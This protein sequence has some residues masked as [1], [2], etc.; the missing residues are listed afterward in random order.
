M[1]TYTASWERTFKPPS[2]ESLQFSAK[3]L[4]KI[5]AKNEVQF[6]IEFKASRRGKFR[7][8]VQVKVKLNGQVEV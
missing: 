5:Q 4:L 7:V 1:C 3:V 6:K 8:Q 2:W